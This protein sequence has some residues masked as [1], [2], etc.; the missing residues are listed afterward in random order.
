MAWAGVPDTVITIHFS[1]LW[2]HMPMPVHII[3]AG[4]DILPDIITD[5]I[6]GIMQEAGIIMD[7]V[8]VPDKSFMEEGTPEVPHMGQQEL[9]KAVKEVLQVSI[10]EQ[11]VLSVGAA[12]VPEH[13][14]E[15]PWQ[16][17]EELPE[18]L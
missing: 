15:K 5:S 14:Q 9:P 1:A 10:T 2:A 3:I 8:I 4:P 13:V 6:R 17:A 12:Q 7:P 18:A 16:T 11:A